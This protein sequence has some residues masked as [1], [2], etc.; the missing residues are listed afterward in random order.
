MIKRIIGG[1]SP[2]QCAAVAGVF[3]FT[4]IGALLLAWA[5]R[6]WNARSI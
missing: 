3:I 6:R 2:A 4:L 1:L 5:F